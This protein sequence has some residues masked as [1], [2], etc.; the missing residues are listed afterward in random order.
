PPERK[1][2][3]VKKDGTARFARGWRGTSAA[4]QKSC[5]RIRSAVTLKNVSAPQR[6][7]RRGMSPRQSPHCWPTGERKQCSFGNGATAWPF[8]SSCPPCAELPRRK[9]VVSTKVVAFCVERN[10]PAEFIL[11]VFL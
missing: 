11:L 4:L 8:C 5:G 7:V 9:L 3:T 6:P 10:V 2:R 1:G